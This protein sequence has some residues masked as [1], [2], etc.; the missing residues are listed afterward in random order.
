MQNQVAEQTQELTIIDKSLDTF[1]GA[2]EILRNNQSR[3][4]KAVA[5][6]QM[7]IAELKNNGGVMNPDLDSRFQKF[8]AN[9]SKAKGEMNEDRKVFTQ[10]MTLIA[11]A[12]TSEENKLDAA[13]A[14]TEAYEIQQ[15]RNAYAKQLHEEEQERQR[16][17]KLQLEKD[18]EVINM[19]A[20]CKKRLS[21]YVSDAIAAEKL[22]INNV[23]NAITL[24]TYEAKKAGL[25]AMQPAYQY[26]HFKE[27]KHGITSRLFT[28]A[29]IDTL[30]LLTISE[31]FTP[32]AELYKTQ[33]AELQTYLI[34]RLE[35]KRQ[36]LEAIKRQQEE[37][38]KERLEM[39]RI[40]AEKAKANEEQRKILEQQQKESEERMRVQRIENERL[41]NERKQREQEEADRI[42]REEEERLRAQ[43]QE[44]ANNKELETTM[45]LFNTAAETAEVTTPKP[46]TRQG[47]EIEVLNPAGWMQIFQFWF[48]E[49]GKSLD[50]EK[51]G[52]ATLDKMKTF[53]EK[54]AHK[55]GTKIDSKFLKYTE[56]FKAVNR[57]Q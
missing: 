52:K 4:A 31:E 17:L 29:E 35:S 45:S 5:V 2:G 39:E 11:A 15:L 51:I 1:K 34:D 54:A 26:S 40:N 30:L 48:T 25:K 18:K 32:M 14:G 16:Q 9:C 3:A 22:R 6:G 50:N 24:D 23:F 55:T 19:R 13:K 42:K 46:E 28:A 38:E 12:F 37:Q 43:E 57:K 47:Y 36:E 44:I 33:I 8:L 21:K 56:T 49:E 53:C 27:F 7:L 41:E 10:T 20:E